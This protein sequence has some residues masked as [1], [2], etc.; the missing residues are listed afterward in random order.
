MAQCLVYSVQLSRSS[1]YIFYVGC[2]LNMTLLA[3][4]YHNVSS[5]AVH[6]EI[7]WLLVLKERDKM[8]VF[9]MQNS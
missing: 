5:N 3:F 4:P 9:Y 1:Q 2:I 7:G 6:H 8:L